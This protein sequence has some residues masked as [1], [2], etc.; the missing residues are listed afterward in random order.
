MLP[1]E[2]TIGNVLPAVM[3]IGSLQ[4][5]GD[6]ATAVLA[7]GNPPAVLVLA[8]AAAP[9]QTRP[10]Q[11]AE[12]TLATAAQGVFMVASIRLCRRV[13]RGP[14]PSVERGAGS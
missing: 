3:P 7:G 10:V 6:A 11:W 9:A 14:S 1:A 12:Q 2:S 5:R 13:V 8:G 4:S